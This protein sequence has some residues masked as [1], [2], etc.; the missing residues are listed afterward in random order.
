MDVEGYL[1]GILFVFCLLVVAAILFLS[2]KLTRFWKAI[3]RS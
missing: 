3:V 1:F 2:D